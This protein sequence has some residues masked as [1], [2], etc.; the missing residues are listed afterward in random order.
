MSTDI[1]DEQSVPESKKPLEL[2]STHGPHGTAAKCHPLG[3]ILKLS[4]WLPHLHFSVS[5][6]LAAQSEEAARF[7]PLDPRKLFLES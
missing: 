3:K 1:F 2:N 4:C 7:R 5:A 6:W